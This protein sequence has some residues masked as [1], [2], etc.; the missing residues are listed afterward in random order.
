MYIIQK[1]LR[2]VIPFRIKYHDINSTT[3]TLKYYWFVLSFLR[4]IDRYGLG[5]FCLVEEALSWYYIAY[6]KKGI[7]SL[8]LCFTTHSDRDL[9][10]RYKRDRLRYPSHSV[11]ESKNRSKNETNIFAAFSHHASGRNFARKSTRKIPS[12]SPPKSDRIE[13]DSLESE[14]S[15]SSWCN[16]IQLGKTKSGHSETSNPL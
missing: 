6:I 10:L 16:P 5:P 8:D 14:N 7:L 12:I 1:L 15:S 11:L 9:W 2:K 3:F 13:A 4:L